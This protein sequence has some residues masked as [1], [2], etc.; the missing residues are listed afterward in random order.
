VNNNDDDDDSIKITILLNHLFNHFLLV[1]LTYYVFTDRKK[2][3]FIVIIL[4]MY[5]FFF[6]IF[7]KRCLN[8]NAV[9][10][11]IVGFNH[12]YILFKRNDFHFIGYRK[13]VQCFESRSV[14]ATGQGRS[15]TGQVLGIRR[16]NV[17]TVAVLLYV[18][19]SLAGLHLVFHR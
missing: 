4:Y 19:R 12:R 8:N 14:I 13:L 17:D 1:F 6:A 11:A 10:I 2:N 7:M 18:G 5:I 3:N 9:T 16:C 15:K